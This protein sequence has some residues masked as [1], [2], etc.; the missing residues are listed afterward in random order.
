MLDSLDA[1]KKTRRRMHRFGWL[2]EACNHCQEDEEQEAAK[3][4][5]DDFDLA[6]AKTGIRRRP[7]KGNSAG[8]GGGGDPE[9]TRALQRVKMV[10]MVSCCLILIN[11]IIG[12][13]ESLVDRVRLRSEFIRLHLL[14]VLQQLHREKHVDVVRQ[15][16]VFEKEMQAD[17]EE[18]AQLS[19]EEQKDMPDQ[20]S[21]LDLDAAAPSGRTS[22]A[23]AHAGARANMANSPAVAAPIQLLQEK[24]LLHNPKALSKLLSLMHALKELPDTEGGYV[25]WMKC[26]QARRATPAP[27]HPRATPAPL[28]RHSR[29][30]LARYP[31]R[32][33]STRHTLGW[34]WGWGQAWL[35]GLRC[36]AT[37]ARANA[38]MHAHAP[39]QC[40][41]AAGSRWWV[42]R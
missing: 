26:E 28:P 16:D 15:V 7:L 38:R 24:V 27:R 34:G 1:L 41:S 25:A 19:S 30:P 33:C 12:F 29:A 9:D 4:D 10:E 36:V 2:V 17:N 3:A 23:M 32:L 20:P 35:G 22:D 40:T 42:C 8:G 37:P 6:R 14:D 18:I 39:T 13:P 21:S 31:T 5:E 11:A